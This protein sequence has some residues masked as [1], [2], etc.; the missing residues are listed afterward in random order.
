MAN[1][2]SAEK[3]IRQNEK[4]RMRNKDQRSKVRTIC[5]NFESLLETGEKSSLEAAYREAASA[6]DT[7]ATKGIIPRARASRKKARLAVRLGAALA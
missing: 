1:N 6:L 5:K 7:A 2:P 3:R 4:R